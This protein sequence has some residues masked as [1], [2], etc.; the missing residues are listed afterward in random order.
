MNIVLFFFNT[1]LGVPDSIIK[2]TSCAYFGA[3]CTKYRGVL[4][5]L[6]GTKV[7]IKVGFKVKI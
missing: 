2:Y 7:T 6:S 1:L 5:I 3:S 4:A